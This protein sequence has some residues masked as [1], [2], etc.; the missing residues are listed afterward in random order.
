M[1]IQHLVPAD[2][3]YVS[4]V[5]AEAL[6]KDTPYPV[7]KHTVRQW[8]SSGKLKITRLGGRT[9]HV[10]FSDLLQV[11]RDMAIRAGRDNLP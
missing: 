1:A 3:E 10:S 9:P 6:L 11:H 2:D 7:T 8:A 5:E 4:Y